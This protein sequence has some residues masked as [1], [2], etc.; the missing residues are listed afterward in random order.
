ML[1]KDLLKRI[2]GRKDEPASPIV[3][4]KSNFNEILWTNNYTFKRQQ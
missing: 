3:C 2:P 4:V 1:L